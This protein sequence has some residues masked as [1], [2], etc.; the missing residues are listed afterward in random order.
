MNLPLNYNKLSLWSTGDDSPALVNRHIEKILRKNNIKTV[1]DFSCG[2]GSQ[3][4]WFLKYGYDVV[5]VDISLGMLNIAKER[6]K[7]EKVRV[8]LLVGDMRSTKIGRF[9]SV[10][11]VFNAIGH[12]TRKGFEKAM[13]NIYSNLNNGGI[14]IFDIFN[15]D[16]KKNKEMKMDATRNFDNIKIRKI[17]Y[18]K[19]DK[20]TGILWCNDQF[21]VKEGNL[22]QKIFKAKFPLQIY[23]LN[24]LEKMLNRNGFEILGL[25]SIDGVK[26]SKKET[27]RIMVTAK[28]NNL[29]LKKSY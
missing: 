10:V 4:F 28:K 6:A 29:F 27:E 5:G 24:E 18:C 22:K 19:L 11:T 7:K 20:N 9:D 16:C 14:Y 2:T 15:L 13:R 21:I 3:V 25:C 12:L 23:T 1:L 26:F 17:Q 8:K